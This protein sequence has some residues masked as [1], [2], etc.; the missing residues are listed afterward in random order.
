MMLKTSHIDDVTM[1]Q[2]EIVGE[3]RLEKSQKRLDDAVAAQLL[4]NLPALRATTRAAFTSVSPEL[5]ALSSPMGSRSVKVLERCH[6]DA[7]RMFKATMK[8]GYSYTVGSY[9]CSS[10]ARVRLTYGIFTI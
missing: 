5:Y 7:C 6:A 10:H 9:S 8:V 4:P 2:C 1:M 3:I